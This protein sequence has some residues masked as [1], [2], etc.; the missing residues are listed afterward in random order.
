MRRLFS[1]CGRM[2]N[3]FRF[4]RIQFFGQIQHSGDILNENNPIAPEADKK[5]QKHPGAEK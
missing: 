2:L 4:L 1:R 5:W 3:R